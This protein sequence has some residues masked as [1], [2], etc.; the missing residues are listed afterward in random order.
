MKLK[1]RFIQSSK[2]NSEIQ[3]RYRV[4]LCGDPVASL[5]IIGFSNR[6]YRQI[7]YSEKKHL[8]VNQSQSMVCIPEV[9]FP[10]FDTSTYTLSGL[11]NDAPTCGPNFPVGSF[12][13]KKGLS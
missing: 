13:T 12:N 8:R 9:S 5:T 11:N 4:A 2:S 6:S 1:L 7:K 3:R 10:V